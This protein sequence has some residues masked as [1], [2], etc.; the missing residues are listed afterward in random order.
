M[1]T[2][3]QNT[4]KEQ[5]LDSLAQ[6]KL[7]AAVK[8][9]VD[10]FLKGLNELI[11][12]SLLSIFDENELEVGVVP[13]ANQP[14]KAMFFNKSFSRSCCYAVQTSIALLISEPITSSMAVHLSSGAS[15]SGSGPP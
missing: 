2:R 6:Y 13:S 14:S 1:Q 8:D 15:W 12:D 4:T 11:P 10:H 3:V 7:A 9:E 5:Y